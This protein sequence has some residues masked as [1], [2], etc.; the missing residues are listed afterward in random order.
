MNNFCITNQPKLVNGKWTYKK[1]LKHGIWLYYDSG[2]E[3]INSPKHWIVF[4]GILWQ[5]KVTDFIE[6]VKQN[7]I[8]YAI[9]ID[10]KS[11]EIQVVN[12]FADSFNL[13]YYAEGRHFVVTNEI[14]VYG[15]SFKINQQ[16]VNWSKH[17][18]SLREDLMTAPHIVPHPELRYQKKENI[19]PLVGV[20]YLGAGYVLTL[21]GWDDFDC[22][23]VI[24]NWFIYYRD[25]GKLFFEK[26]QHNYQS[27]LATA[28]QIISENCERIKEKYGNQ[29]VHFCSTGVDSLTLQSYLDGVPMY[30]LYEF[31]NK[32]FDLV[33]NLYQEYG[34]ALHYF[35]TEIMEDVF[36]SQLSKLEKTINYKPNH[37]I[38]MYMRDMY[39]LNDCVIIQ[40]SYGDDVFWH[41]R[42]HVIRH[43]VHRWG[44]TDAEKIW[45]R[46]IPH[47]GF[48]GPDG[49][50]VVNAGDPDLPIGTCSKQPRIN[51]INKY[52]SR[53]YTDFAP[54]LTA[55]RYIHRLPSSQFLTDQLIIDPYADLRLF[56]L[57][58]SSDI[59]TQEASMLDAQI[60]KDMIS[61][62]LLPYLT[63]YKTG[64]NFSVS[65]SD[66]KT[67]KENISLQYHSFYKKWID[68]FLKNLQKC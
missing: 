23:P 22:Q 54:A 60:Q 43:A 15:P 32:N 50:A 7:G 5:G 55:Y 18:L 57:L 8:F 37:L 62:K 24:T 29:L 40:G 16:W 35:D 65:Y 45:D 20:K 56:S 14:K 68:S 42:R 34:G 26:P 28:K 12:D 13:T 63:P 31:I 41:K 21:Q 3:I 36:K 11:G 61:G 46:C 9:V 30:G 52:I 51:S 66:I 53:P 49:N 58:P 47:Y 33:N 1:L 10:K 25:I 44:M 17:R 27:A 4:C 19:T 67:E 38:F 2:V 39:E 59:P 64:V 6:S 48:G